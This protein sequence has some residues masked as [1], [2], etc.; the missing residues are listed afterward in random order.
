V[1]RTF[2]GTGGTV[3]VRKIQQG[4]DDVAWRVVLEHAGVQIKLDVGK[5]ALFALFDECLD[6]LVARVGEEE[7]CPFCHAEG[8]H[9]RECDLVTSLVGALRE[10]R[11]VEAR[12]SE[13]DL[14]KLARGEDHDVDD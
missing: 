13:R 5:H 11:P 9:L 8:N 3:E 6:E 14:D 4:G 1:S 10:I 7:C 12:P 2:D